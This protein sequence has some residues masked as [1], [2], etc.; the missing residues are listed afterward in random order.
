MLTTEDLWGLP[1]E[2]QEN[3]VLSNSWSCYLHCTSIRQSFANFFTLV[4]VVLWGNVGKSAWSCLRERL[5]KRQLG[6]DKRWNSGFGAKVHST[7]ADYSDVQEG[8]IFHTLSVPEMQCEEKPL[9]I[10]DLVKSSQ[11]GFKLSLHKKGKYNSWSLENL[12]WTISWLLINVCYH[13]NKM[14]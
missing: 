1:V 13:E 6:G 12:K 5:W 2:G 7:A 11:V 3:R 8:S 9:N 14:T 4:R 10:L